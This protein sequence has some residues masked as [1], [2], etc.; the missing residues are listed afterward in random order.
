M[1]TF[2]RIF[3]AATILAFTSL[4]GTHLYTGG[5]FYENTTCSAPQ[6]IYIRTLNQTIQPGDYVILGLPKELPKLNKPKGYLLLKQIAADEGT[7]YIVKNSQLIVNN[8]SY[9]YANFDYLP[10]LIEG[11]YTVPKD[12]FLCLNEPVESFDSR[13]LGPI[14]KKHILCK[15]SIFIDYAE[16]AKIYYKLFGR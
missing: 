16:L 13:Y 10:Q 4:Y 12:N 6:G 11:K 8:H 14:H 2:P 3:V 9:P 15:V 5:I 7:T 1:M